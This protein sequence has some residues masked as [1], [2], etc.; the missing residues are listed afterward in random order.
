MWGKDCGERDGTVG[1]RCGDGTVGKWMW[2]RLLAANGCG[3]GTEEMDVG[4]VLGE[5]GCGEGSW[6]QMD[7]GR[8]L[9]GKGMCGGDCDERDV[10]R[11]RWGNGY[12]EQ[13]V[14][15]EINGGQ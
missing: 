5:N 9:W 8:G 3:Q 10:W 2:G 13:M 7:V 14:G 1:N 4:G 6:G 15:K 11:G 12:R